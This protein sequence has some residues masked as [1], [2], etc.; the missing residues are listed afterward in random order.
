LPAK[1]GT[2]KLGSQAKSGFVLLTQHRSEAQAGKSAL[3]CLHQVLTVGEERLPIVGSRI[4]DPHPP[5]RHE[6]P[7][8]G[9]ALGESQR[10]QSVDQRQTAGILDALFDDWQV[11]W[12]AMLAEYA[13]EVLFGGVCGSLAVES[14]DESSSQRRL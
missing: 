5:L 1:S 9:P 10:D 12:R 14:P 11:F 3:P 13:G 8:F 2:W 6:A 4:V 7:R